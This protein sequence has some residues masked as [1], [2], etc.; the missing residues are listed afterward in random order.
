MI[1]RQTIYNKFCSLLDG[2]AVFTG[3]LRLHASPCSRSDLLSRLQIV[4]AADFMLDPRIYTNI[5]L[6]PFSIF[7][8]PIVHRCLGIPAVVSA[9]NKWR[10][11]HMI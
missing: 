3:L 9:I 10:I 4:Q 7:M 1:E 11:I 5:A 6:L 8:T 2:M